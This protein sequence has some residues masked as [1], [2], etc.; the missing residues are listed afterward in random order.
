MKSFGGWTCALAVLVLVQSVPD[1]A[2]QGS[3]KLPVTGTA[4]KTGS[5]S[6]TVAVTRFETRDNQLV[7]IGFIGGTVTHRNRTIGTALVGEVAIPVTVR[8][9]GMA[10]VNGRPATEPQLRRVAFVNPTPPARVKRVQA[11]ACPVVDVVLGPLTVNV[12]GVD[13]TID[14]IVVQLAGEQGTPL[15]DLVCQVNALIGN[16]A[17]LVGVVNTILT[18]LTTLLGGGLAGAIPGA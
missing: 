18:L 5:F 7:A 12:E 3:L 10:P 2:A 16:V 9:G 6:G 13:V 1:A 14:P 4:A 8:A 15:G 11:A 17:G